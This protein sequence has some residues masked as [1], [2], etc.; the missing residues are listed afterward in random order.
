LVAV[1]EQAKPF[2][3]MGWHFDVP[4]CV[5]VVGGG[6]LAEDFPHSKP[7]RKAGFR[8][9][10]HLGESLEFTVTILEIHHGTARNSP[11]IVVFG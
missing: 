11:R 4:E 10:G 5:A 8:V 9:A 3:L 6:S 1:L 2:L 7:T